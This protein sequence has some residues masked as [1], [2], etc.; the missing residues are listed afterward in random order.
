MGEHVQGA[1]GVCAGHRGSRAREGLYA[2]PR[3]LDAAWYGI[4]M[5]LFT[6]SNSYL[7]FHVRLGNQHLFSK[8]HLPLSLDSRT[9][10]IKDLPGEQ[11]AI[12]GDTQQELVIKGERHLRRQSM[13]RRLSQAVESRTEPAVVQALPPGQPGYSLLGRKTLSQKRHETRTLTGF[14]E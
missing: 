10:L 6:R 14:W 4:S 2:G 8:A 3:T 12:L 5:S 1:V 9:I 7:L 13:D 11:A